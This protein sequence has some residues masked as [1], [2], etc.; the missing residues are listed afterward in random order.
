[1]QEAGRHRLPT[2]EKGLGSGA[3]SERGAGGRPVALRRNNSYG[4]KKKEMLGHENK[5]LERTSLARKKSFFKIV[6]KKG[7]SSVKGE[8]NHDGA[9]KEGGSL[10]V[11]G[12]K[13]RL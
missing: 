6:R 8:S 9:T 2:E 13:E 7:R 3:G 11:F 4:E 1:M 10:A 5:S 12:K